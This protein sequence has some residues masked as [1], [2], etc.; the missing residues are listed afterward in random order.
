MMKVGIGGIFDGKQ[1]Q[2][3]SALNHSITC[4]GTLTLNSFL[5][6]FC[7]DNLVNIS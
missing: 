1:A 5:H 6:Y 4:E 7:S 2:T 3:Y